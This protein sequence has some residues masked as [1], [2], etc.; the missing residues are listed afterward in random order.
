MSSPRAASPGTRRAYAGVIDR[1]AV[2][3]G[4]HRQ[5]AVVATL[6]QPVGSRRVF[7]GFRLR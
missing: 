7:A 3:L 2:E 5:L 1:L 6:G 4:L